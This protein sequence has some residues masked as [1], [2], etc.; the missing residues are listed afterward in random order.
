MR[1]ERKIHMNEAIQQLLERSAQAQAEE[2]G[3]SLSL[4]VTDNDENGD[5]DSDTFSD[6]DAQSGG[7]ELDAETVP[8]LRGG[9][10]KRK[11]ASRHSPP[12]LATAHAEFEGEQRS[13]RAL[14]AVLGEVSALRHQ[15][16]NSHNRKVVNASEA[17]QNLEKQSLASTS[18]IVNTT[19]LFFRSIEAE[20]YMSDGN[21]TFWRSR[22][23]VMHKVA[24]PLHLYYLHWRL[25]HCAIP[26][27]DLL[28]PEAVALARSSMP[29]AREI[30]Q[31]TPQLAAA[32]LDEN[33]ADPGA[34]AIQELAST[35][36]HA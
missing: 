8:G 26:K 25:Q 4:S 32:T 18:Q 23:M 34:E 12:V 27:A 6:D 16:L 1:V 15:N 19:S 13:L 31:S 24:N 20:D 2:I 36:S 21:E 7:A 30:F 14:T 10:E 17:F 28:S 3:H 33:P 22:P 5:F 35:L 9:S 11:R 29:S